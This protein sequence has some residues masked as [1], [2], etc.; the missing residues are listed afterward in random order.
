M[1]SA[2]ISRAR[3]WASAAACSAGRMLPRKRTSARAASGVRRGCHSASQPGSSATVWATQRWKSWTACQRKVGRS[4]TARPSRWTG[5]PA[6]MRRTSPTVS[7]PQMALRCTTAWGTAASAKYSA[8][9]PS[10]R[11]RRPRG[12]VMSSR[13]TV[14][15]TA[16]SQ[17]IGARRG[18]PLPPA[19]GGREQ[20]D[21]ARQLR[22]LLLP[23]LG[24]EDLL[25][26]EED[27]AHVVGVAVDPQLVAQLRLHRAHQPDHRSPEE[28]GQ[29]PDLAQAALLHQVE[30]GVGLAQPQPGPGQPL[31]AES[32]PALDVDQLGAGCRQRSRPA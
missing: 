12:V 11:S 22:L 23:S 27:I 3:D 9:P 15:A 25:G 17:A 21:D 18:G 32:G 8:E 13:W 28:S 4:L 14:P 6:R 5:R 24:L 29:G 2:P 31:P 10:W 7:R 30:E 26:G 20:R 16:I 19:F 1:L